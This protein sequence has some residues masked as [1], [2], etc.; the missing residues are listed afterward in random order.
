[1]KLFGRRPKQ[2]EL[3]DFELPSLSDAGM[4]ALDSLRRDDTSAADVAE[5]IETDPRLSVEVLRLAN[6]A[7]FGA[8]TTIED[9]AHAV[10]LMGRGNLESLVISVSVQ[11]A[12]PGTVAGL[13]VGAFWRCAFARANVARAIAQRVC[14]DEASATFTAAL[15][16]DM[17]VPLLAQRLGEKYTALLVEA[18][19]GE[20]PLEALEREKFGWDHAE[21]GAEMCTTWALPDGLAKSI[22][23]HHDYEQASP[24]SLAARLG[25]TPSAEHLSEVA[26]W[27]A[28]SLELEPEDVLRLI[29]RA[30]DSGDAPASAG[31]A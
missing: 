21:V 25:E 31:A 16:C 23:A 8:R 18:A 20:Q 27:A 26:D 15:L 22:A 3:G 24:T 29:A 10:Q 28:E 12:L 7:A 4:R 2:P 6:S 19:E 9:V 17:A 5:V 13:D 30:L 11:R 1:M 14:R